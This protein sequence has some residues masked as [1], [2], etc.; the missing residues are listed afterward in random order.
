MSGGCAP[1]GREDV[2]ET[3]RAKYRI[4]ATTPEGHFAYVTGAEGARA[5]G[6]EEDLLAA[7]PGPVLRRFAGVGNPY[8]VERPAPGARVLDVG[9]GSGTDAF[10]AARLVGPQGAVIGLDL[11]EE[12]LDAPREA[13]DASPVPW[14]SFVEGAADEMPFPDASFDLIVSNGVLNLVPDKDA[15]FREL[16]RVLRPKGLLAAADL[17]LLDHLP[18]EFLTLKDG[19]SS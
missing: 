1:R 6:Y 18:A 19:W 8:S 15:A 5:L 12:M 14:L 2:H 7:V 16:R 9:C 13:L 4:W 17:V 3:V 11:T 10:V